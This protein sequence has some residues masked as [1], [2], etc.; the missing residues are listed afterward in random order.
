MR[1]Q[2]HA[3]SSAR[4]RLWHFSTARHSGCSRYCSW[5]VGRAPHK[6]RSRRSDLSAQHKSCNKQRSTVSSTSCSLTTLTLPL[7]RR[8]LPATVL[9]MMQPWCHPKQR[10]QSRCVYIDGP[11]RLVHNLFIGNPE[12]CTY[13]TLIAV[14][15]T[16]TCVCR[17]LWRSHGRRPSSC[18][19][20]D[21][22]VCFAE[23]G[24]RSDHLKPSKANIWA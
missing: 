17:P 1:S 18:A 16:R 21:H 19:K 7:M 22:E 24:R 8:Y 23:V 14:W 4:V 5:G 15:H 6:N 11:G 12:K 13:I 3:G 9:Q 10:C 2:R 20:T